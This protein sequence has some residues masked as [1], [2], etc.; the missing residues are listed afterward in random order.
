MTN[1]HN[2]LND[3]PFEDLPATWTTFNLAS[4]S[5]GKSLWDYQQSALQNGLKALHKYYKDFEGSKP[6]FFQWYVDNQIELDA[7]LNLGKKR[8]NESLLAPYYPIAE[9]RIPYSHF[10][11][12]MGFWMATGSGKTLVIVKMLEVLHALIQR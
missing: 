4:F 1:L 7:D 10:I 11:N 3:V 12:R 9:N 5:R 6:R 2:L 8:D